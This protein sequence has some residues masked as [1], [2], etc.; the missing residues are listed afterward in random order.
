MWTLARFSVIC[1]SVSAFPSNARW[2][3]TG[4]TFVEP[5]EIQTPVPAKESCTT[6]RRKSHTTWRMRWYEAVMLSDAV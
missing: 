4:I 5:S 2:M 1:L 3:G 6:L